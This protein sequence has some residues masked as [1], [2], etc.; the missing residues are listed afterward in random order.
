MDWTRAVDGYCE[1]IDASFW[2]EPINAVTNLAF[3]VAALVMWRKRGDVPRARLLCAILFAIGIG[4]FLFHTFAQPWAGLADVAPILGF[5]LVYLYAMNRVGWGWGPLASFVGML[6]FL[7]YAAA[8]VPLFELIPGLGSSAGY[9]PVPLLI[10]IYAALLAGRDP[11]L[12]RGLAIGAGLLIL[13]LFFR[14]IDLP[15]CDALPLGTHFLWHV[16]NAVML[17][18][19]IEVYARAALGKVR[20]EG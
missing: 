4:S 18:W 13:S 3:I 5:I 6:L 12:A 9:G 20:A 14:T 7:P 11:A 1:R 8:L 10:L 19:M 15:L 16:L 17:A 2:S